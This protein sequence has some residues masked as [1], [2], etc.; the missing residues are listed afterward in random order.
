MSRQTVAYAE[1]ATAMAF[2]GSSVIAGDVVTGTFPLPL[3]ITLRFSLATLIL[4]PILLAREGIPKLGRNDAATVGLQTLL[5]VVGFNLFLLLG[6]R[7]TT[8]GESGIVLGTTPAVIGLIAFLVLRER[9][10]LSRSVGIALAVCG[11]AALSFA[12]DGDGRGPNPLLGNALV[13]GTVVCEALFSILGKMATARLRALTIA[14]LVSLLGA[15]S[16]LPFALY[17]AVDF[18]FG[19]VDGNAWMA[20]VYYAVGATVL[21]YLLWYHGLPHVPAGVAGV[22]TGIIPLSAVALAVVL[23]DE[24]PRLGHLVGIICVLAALGLTLRGEGGAGS[25]EAD[26]IAMNYPVSPALGDGGER[27]GLALA[28]GQDL[29][30]EV[31]ERQLSGN[32]VDVERRLAAD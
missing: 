8:A 4:A 18:D 17:T 13:F 12:G 14:T 32:V 20:L 22:F 26:D 10:N 19:A 31:G 5:G 30:V 23:L 21:P 3:A 15:L 11:V 2:V 7:Y 6:L 1:L 24:P 16:F 9:L 25:A 29:E 27:A 28:A